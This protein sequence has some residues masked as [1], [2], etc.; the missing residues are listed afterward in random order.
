MRRHYTHENDN[1][2]NDNRPPAQMWAWLFIVT[3]IFW[4]IVGSVIGV[5]MFE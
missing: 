5:I 2:N 3:V 1:D 4:V